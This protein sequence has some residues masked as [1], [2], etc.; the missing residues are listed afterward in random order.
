LIAAAAAS[1]FRVVPL[2]CT[3]DRLAIAG[4]GV[5]RLAAGASCAGIIPGHAIALV[6]GADGRVTP[7]ALDAPTRPASELPAST[8]VLAPAAPAQ[9][10]SGDLVTVTI[11]V[12]VPPRTP[13]TDD[14]YVSTDRSDWNP[15]EIRMDRVDARHY[16]LGLPL[17]RGAQLAFRITRGSF[18]TTERDAA[19]ALPP[20]H[21]IVGAPG[22]ETRVTIAAWADID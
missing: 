12:F 7:H 18:G 15:A 8:Y 22:A 17:R 4:G 14:I 11:D 13:P 3:D 9:A 10:D 5:V 21:V 16:R 1:L 2:A 20:A 19:R 6:V